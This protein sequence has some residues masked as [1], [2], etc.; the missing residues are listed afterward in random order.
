MNFTGVYFINNASGI[1]IQAEMITA[2][3]HSINIT[4]TNT[5]KIYA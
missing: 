1:Q 2:G 4:T 3:K 5:S